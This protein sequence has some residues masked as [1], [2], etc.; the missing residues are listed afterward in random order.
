[1]CVLS[2]LGG[3]VVFCAPFATKTCQRLWDVASLMT[4]RICC[5][6]A[7]SKS[8]SPDQI[9]SLWPFLKHNL[10]WCEPRWVN[11]AAIGLSM[12]PLL[13]VPSEG[14]RKSKIET[15]YIL[16]V[17]CQQFQGLAQ[18]LKKQIFMSPFYFLR[19]S[20]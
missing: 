8:V 6:L 3:D 4:G 19:D 9:E 16:T 2:C 1:M 15:F 17:G 20:V 13:E 10:N 18:E 5:F 11:R 14:Y 7:L 12:F